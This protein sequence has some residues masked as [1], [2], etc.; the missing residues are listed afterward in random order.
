MRRA[1]N[2]IKIIKDDTTFYG[3]SL[4]Y[5]YCA[6]HEWGT[7][8]M[9]DK[10]GIDSTKMG[11]NGRSITKC[12]VM[13]MKDYN[14]CVLTSRKPWFS[15]Q[16]P[17]ENIT[18][19]DLLSHDIQYMYNDFECAWD[20]EDFCIATKNK[21]N[22][23]YLEELNEAFNTKNIVISFIKSDLPVF[24]NSSLS[25]LIKDRLPESVTESMY[26]VD[27]SAID[28]VEYEAKIGITKLKEETRGN[29]YK[30][31]KYFVACSPKWISYDD[32][33][34][35]EKRKK[36]MKTKYDIMY[37]VNY[38][39]DDDNYGWYKAEDIIKWLSTPGLKLKSLNN[40]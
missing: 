38:S 9:K 7:K 25:I 23:K 5:D 33:K 36:E 20:E 39:D 14:L 27:K 22:F 18:V 32:A 16:K 30:G 37:W 28:L 6:E 31:D 24:A 13:F 12:D 34:Y 29:G 35:R 17:K 10:F 21:D 1:F 3:V 15:W 26:S 4:G 8:K 11:V 40:G 19:K 2:D